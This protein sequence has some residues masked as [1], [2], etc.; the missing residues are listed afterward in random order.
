M[1]GTNEIARQLGVDHNTVSRWATRWHGPTGQGRHRRLDETDVLVAQAWYTLTGSQRGGMN[2][3]GHWCSI[4]ETA[5]RAQPLRWLLI[6]DGYAETF[7]RAEHAAE[8]WWDSG[9]ASATLI[10]LDPR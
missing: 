7:H 6:A 9:L 8:A 3:V 2:N 1:V 10:D 4:A 5:I